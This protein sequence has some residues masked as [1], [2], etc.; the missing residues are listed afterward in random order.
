MG[1]A[2]RGLEG[3]LERHMELNM[4]VRS[5]AFW[6]IDHLLT[7]AGVEI[8]AI[9]IKPSDKRIECGVADSV[10]K[11]GRAV[12]GF[13]SSDCRCPSHLFQVDDFRFLSGLGF[14]PRLEGGRRPKLDESIILSQ[15]NKRD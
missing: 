2:L 15:W 5:K 8:E 4:G 3:R 7:E 1:S 14:N 10:S 9:Y 13:G 12:R 11:V 6:H